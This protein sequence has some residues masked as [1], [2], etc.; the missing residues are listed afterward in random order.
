MSYERKKRLKNTLNLLH[1]KKQMT[2]KEIAQLLNVSDVTVRRDLQDLEDEGLLRRTHGGA[3]V[4]GSS[5]KINDVY[6]IDEQ[7]ERNVKKK[8]TIGLRAS[9]LIQQNETVFFDSGTTVPFVVKYLDKEIP[10]T[11]LC[12]T[13]QIALEFYHRKNTNLILTGGYF[14]R[15]SNVF[16]STHGCELIRDIR[17]DKAF[18]STGGVDDSLGLTTYF[19]FE[20]EIKK[21]M[22]ASS[23]QIILVTDSSKFGKVSISYFAGLRDIDTIITDDGIDDHYREVIQNLGIELLIAHS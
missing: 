15:D 7:T 12:Y 18:I 16:H 13:F 6:L 11:A 8:S 5:R 21:A 9:S 17:A 10:L 1:Q 23:K 4:F 20:A 14:N 19:Y 3:T 22:I 2:V